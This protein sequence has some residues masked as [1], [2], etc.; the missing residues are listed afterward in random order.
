VRHSNKIT[1]G[2]P[3]HN[4][5]STLVD[6]IRSV[7]AQT[8]DEW[9][10]ILVDD[11]SS[12]K[13]LEIALSIT[14][15]RVRVIHDGSRKF[16]SHRL[17]QI[18]DSATGVYLARMDADDMMHPDRLRQQIEFLDANKSID[19]VGTC[20]I[21]IDEKNRPLGKRGLRPP[22]LDALSVLRYTLLDH[23]TITARREWFLNNQYDEV[24]PRLIRCEDRELWCRTYL[25]STFAR[26]TQPLLFYR[27]PYAVNMTNYI[28]S[29]RALR[30]IYINYGP[31]MVGWTKSRVLVMESFLKEF[32][33]R[34]LNLVRLQGIL[35]RLRNHGL[36]REEYSSA[37][38]LINQV[39]NTP[40]PGLDNM[41]EVSVR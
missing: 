13:S 37:A 22:A 34:T 24:D 18:A 29:C 21:T 15:S 12:D 38:A 16:L 41:L 31:S 23:P 1:V 6:A 19:V 36:S 33:Y 7:F 4:C 10:L 35:V 5:E 27:E 9:E 32:T 28:N 8:I 17:N 40:V 25:T 2:I 14:D 30:S 26:L 11:G 3:F 39:S 20:V